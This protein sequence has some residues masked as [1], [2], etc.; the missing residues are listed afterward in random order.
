MICHWEWVTVDFWRGN[1]LSGIPPKCNIH[2]VRVCINMEHYIYRE[3]LYITLLY[4]SSQSQGFA[5]TLAFS[6]T[7]IAWSWAIMSVY[8]REKEGYPP[9]PCAGV[10]GPA[11]K[12]VSLCVSVSP[13]L[14]ASV[15]SQP[16]FL[17]CATVCCV[18]RLGSH[19]CGSFTLH[20]YLNGLLCQQEMQV[21]A[22]D[23]F[24]KMHQ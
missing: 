6:W 4:G 19:F 23:P 17:S 14:S 1:R 12:P 24:S 13:S 18:L 5:L 15:H 21:K 10:V 2:R 3:T 11:Y 7:C 9:P 22:T 16:L 8:T 20:F